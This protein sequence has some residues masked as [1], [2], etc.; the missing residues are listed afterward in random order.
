MHSLPDRWALTAEVLIRE[1]N[2]HRAELFCPDDDASDPSPIS[3]RYLDIMR[4]ATT[5]EPMLGEAIVEYFWVNPATANRDLSEVW[6]SR[7]MFPL[8]KPK[9]SQ[10][11]SGQIED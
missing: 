7:T 4:R 1:H 6:F 2:Q 11:T 9:L 8:L 3:V 5:S 10:G